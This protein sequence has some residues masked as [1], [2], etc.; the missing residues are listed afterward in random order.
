[1]R[2]TSSRAGTAEVQLSGQPIASLGAGDFFGEIALIDGR[3]RTA[4]VVASHDMVVLRIERNAF[5]R[6]VDEQPATRHGILMALTQRI[7]NDAP[8]P[9]D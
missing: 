4:S 7:R 8:S 6:L 9:S 2:F 5:L 1:M 3:P